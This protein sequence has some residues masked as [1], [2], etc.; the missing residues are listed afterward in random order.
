MLEYIHHTHVSDLG[1]TKRTE[2]FEVY[3]TVRDILQCKIGQFHAIVDIK[4]FKRAGAAHQRVNS[5]I[6]DLATHGEI[7]LYQVLSL[8]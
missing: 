7:K 5:I 8:G 1:E 4:G 3:T 2:V 6:R